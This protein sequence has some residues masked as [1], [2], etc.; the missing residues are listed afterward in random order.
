MELKAIKSICQSPQAVSGFLLS[1]VNEQ[2]FHYDPAVY[3]FKR[4]INLVHNH[5]NIPD[6][7]ELCSDPVIPESAR[8]ILIKSDYL[9]V[10]TPLK[11]RNLVATLEKYR[12]ARGLLSMAESTLV[13]LEKEHV[14]VEAMVDSASD[15]LATVRSRIDVRKSLLHMGKENNS[16]A[17]V[18]ELLG[19][20][21]PNLV[22]TGFKQWDDRNGGIPNGA[23]FVIGATTS[24]GKSTVASQ[25]LINITRAGENVCLVPL[26]MTDEESMARILS[27]L[28]GVPLGKIIQKKTSKRERIKIVKAYKKYIGTL[29]EMDSRYTIFSP[30]EDMTIEEILF[31]LKPYGHKVILID[32][33]NLLKGVDGEDSW[34]Q[35]GKVARFCKV[36]AKNNN[37]III[38]LAQLSEEGKIRYSRAVA[39]HASLCWV[40]T[41]DDSTRESGVI[42]VKQTKARN[43]D[44]F[45]FS[46]NV[47]FET[48]RVTSS[49]SDEV[50]SHS[51]TSDEKY[52]ND[53]NTEEGD[54]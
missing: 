17:M 9:P 26:E 38:L 7:S 35:L 2:T 52:L 23:L 14:D 29:K 16:A 40:W 27:N 37:K 31:L 53:L 41:M 24:G 50:D 54:D 48:M 6:Y 10:K 5:G 51:D 46:L 15:R 18:K 11:G 25:L 43:Q 4:I 47:D 28:S 30:E 1:S 13:G 44:P 19:K 34:R 45:P 39:E 33:I 8:K 12:Q 36:F 20:A 22:S 3:A 49:E 32:Y 42:H 21:K